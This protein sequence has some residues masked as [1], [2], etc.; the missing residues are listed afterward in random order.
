M[1]LES[2]FGPVLY[3]RGADSTHWRVRALIGLSEEMQ[4]PPVQ[5]QSG[6]V[7][8]KHLDTRL[9]LAIWCYDLEFPRLAEDHSAHYGI[10]EES[11]TVC[12]PGTE[13]GLHLA[14]T[15]CNGSETG[16]LDYPEENRNRLWNR[17]QDAHR[18]TAFHLL[19]QGGDQL[20]A[21]PV[22]DRVPELARR[23]DGQKPD[24]KGPGVA[25]ETVSAIRDYYFERYVK[26]WSQHELAPLLASIPSLM[27]WDDHDIFDGW[28]SHPPE[29]QAS[30]PY[31]SVYD[32][33]RRAFRIFQLG[34]APEGEA[35][36][37]H[38]GFFSKSLSHLG[39]VYR[40]GD[41]GLLAP[42]LRSTRTTSQVMSRSAWQG[43]EA[44]LD[45]LNGC[46]T[47][48][49]LSSVPLLNL[50]LTPVERL[51]VWFPRQQGYQDDLRDQW[52]SFAHR[53]E[54][55]RMMNQLF[56]YAKRNEARILV[57]SGE[58]HLGAFGRAHNERHLIHQLI[59]SGIVH[60]PPPRAFASALSLLSLILRPSARG[61]RTRMQP[62]PG[63]GRRYLAERNWLELD[64]PANAG[65]RARWHAEESGIS[66][67]VE[68]K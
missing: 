64:L 36:P 62:I 24:T 28:G 55:T 65:P 37:H 43:L 66:A 41:V 9:G 17:L 22:W 31:R 52:Q 30:E 46:R 32:G 58:I 11:W 54:W 48:I 67:W 50:D 15:A 51:M 3:F 29:W 18:V 8:A 45:H 12:I 40:I 53:R 27:M 26:L 4:P 23:V 25:R 16:N 68:L 13:S 57:T 21:D 14:F 10:G 59:S 5:I 2:H 56:A 1:P 6:V 49:L 20:Y 39:W 19:L 42:D 61:I 60:P 38:N 33:A 44:A 7:P 63:F 47:L 35:D 34:L